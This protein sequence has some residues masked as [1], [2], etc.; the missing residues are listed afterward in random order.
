M[1][2]TWKKPN[3][4]TL[5]NL[6]EIETKHQN[7]C[8]NQL[9]VHKT[10]QDRKKIQFFGSWSKIPQ[11]S[12]HRRQ[13]KKWLITAD[14][15]G[16]F[17]L[18]EVR[19]LKENLSGDETKLTDLR[20]VEHDLFGSRLRVSVIQ[21]TTNDVVENGRVHA[22]L[23]LLRHYKDPTRSKLNNTN[24]SFYLTKVSIFRT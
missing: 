20:L 14:L 22:S 7:T 11:R 1:N 5:P 6:S 15:D 17:E 8:L 21:Q 23:P 18:K 16:S 9:M 19:L 4:K 12:K 10:N 2:I 24:R 13:K 3:K